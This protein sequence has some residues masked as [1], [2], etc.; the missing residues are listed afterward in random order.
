M[1]SDPREVGFFCAPARNQ[2][3]SRPTRAPLL[4]D[5][6][7]QVCTLMRLQDVLHIQPFPTSLEGAEELTSWLGVH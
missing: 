3:E 7:V 1:I 6:K 5:K 4:R 2:C